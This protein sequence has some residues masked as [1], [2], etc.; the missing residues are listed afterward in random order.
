MTAG[1]AGASL[2]ARFPPPMPTGKVDDVVARVQAGRLRS[3]AFS[4]RDTFK[5][6]VVQ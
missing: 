3:W 4:L 1:V 6:R 5:S 2:L